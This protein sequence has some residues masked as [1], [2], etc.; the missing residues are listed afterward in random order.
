MTQT[1]AEKDIADK[2]VQEDKAKMDA[3]AAAKKV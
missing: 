3:D 1:Q 2:K